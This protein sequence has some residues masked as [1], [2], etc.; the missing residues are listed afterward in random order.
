MNRKWITAGTIVLFSV[1]LVACGAQ[2]TPNTQSDTSSQS[3]SSVSQTAGN[4]QTNQSAK[5]VLEQ[6][7][8]KNKDL[9]TVALVNKTEQESSANKG[10]VNTQTMDAVAGFDP[11]TGAPTRFAIKIVEQDGS[12]TATQEMI[13]PGGAPEFYI[14]EGDE[15]FR[16]ETVSTEEFKL[17]LNPN[18]HHLI[19]LVYQ[20]AADFALE[21]TATSYKFTNTNR[22]FDFQNT[23]G[24]EYN[25]TLTGNLTQNDLDKKIELEFDKETL[26]LKAVAI[27]L[28]VEKDNAFLRLT[29]T[30][31]FSN[32]NQVPDSAFNAPN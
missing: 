25:F 13:V 23:F 19:D 1:L 32:W 15:P 14:K 26:Y 24:P 6:I 20:S 27:D 11:A 22:N 18:Y 8:A 16:K 12:K 17:T 29:L 10:V 30:S 7:V 3:Q 9:T 28:R 2:P 31:D 21:E 4:T 5:E